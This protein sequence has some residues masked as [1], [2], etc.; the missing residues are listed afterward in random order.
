MVGSLGWLRIR[1]DLRLVL[2]F[3]VRGKCGSPKMQN[4]T[5]AGTYL[6][7]DSQPI[8]YFEANETAP[9]MPLV[10]RHGVHLQG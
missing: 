9:G 2:D 1:S 3:D 7:Q 5:A 10:W 6:L 4:V 8:C